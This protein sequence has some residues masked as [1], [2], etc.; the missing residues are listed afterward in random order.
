MKRKIKHL[1]SINAHSKHKLCVWM[2]TPSRH[3]GKSTCLFIQWMI[4]QTIAGNRQLP[5]SVVIVYNT[6]RNNDDFSRSL[7]SIAHDGDLGTMIH[8]E[9]HTRPDQGLDSLTGIIIRSIRTHNED[10]CS[11]CECVQELV[12]KRSCNDDKACILLIHFV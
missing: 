4:I 1:T 5:D 2:Q 3:T 7:L 8:A 9:A 10:R 11:L 12:S 6:M